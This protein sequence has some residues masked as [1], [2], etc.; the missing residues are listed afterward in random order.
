[1]VSY[2]QARLV[3]LHRAGGLTRLRAALEGKCDH[4]PWEA[5]PDK[6]EVQINYTASQNQRDRSAGFTVGTHTSLIGLIL[7]LRSGAYATP[8]DGSFSRE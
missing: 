6:A 7:T 2:F 4:C 8:P 3:A 5:R 1:M